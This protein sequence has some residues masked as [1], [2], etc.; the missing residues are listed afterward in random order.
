MLHLVKLELKKG[1]LGG[2]VYGALIAL[3]AMAGLLL[4]MYFVKEEGAAPVF[5][6]R[7]DMLKA[8]NTIAS[9]T[10]IIY[11]SALLS[12]L[13]IGEFKDKTMTLLFAY[14]VSRKQ[15]IFA[16]LSI[17]FV[18]C[19]VNVVLA[20]VLLGSMMLALDHYV[21]Q[22]SGSISTTQLLQYGGYVVLQAVG[23]AGMSLL[24]LLVGLPR[25]S[26]AATIVA[27]IFIVSIV[28]SN[29]FGFT[30]SSIVAI[31]LS[32][33]AVGIFGTYLSFRNIDRQDVA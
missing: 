11:A 32:L 27:S 21:G 26:I 31:P 4:L 13:I 22:L 6:D 18:W 2:Y 1:R 17:V 25:R 28:C 16:K 30:L 33:T 24:P 19:F 12:K 29:N 15:L 9:A 7:M 23:A 14:P 3:A 8:V 10:F 20:N 5:K